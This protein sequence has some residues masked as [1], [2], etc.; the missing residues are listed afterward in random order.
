MQKALHI[1]DA[2]KAVFENIERSRV[3]GAGR[4]DIFYVWGKAAGEKAARHSSP[5]GLKDKTLVVNVDSTAWIYQLRLQEEMLLG[6]I[7]KLIK[8]NDIEKIRFRT[9]EITKDKS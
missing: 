6:K 2:I 8:S 9:G 4:P 7:K 5:A 3:G 1:G